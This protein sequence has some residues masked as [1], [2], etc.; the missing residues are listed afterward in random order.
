MSPIDESPMK[1]AGGE[2][3]KHSDA[4]V[5]Q[6]ISRVQCMGA[7]PNSVVKEGSC[8]I[9]FVE[10]T[11]GRFLPTG[12]DQSLPVGGPGCPSACRSVEPNVL[13]IMG[14]SILQVGDTRPVHT[15]RTLC[16][17]M[18]RVGQFCVSETLGKVDLQKWAKCGPLLWA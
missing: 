8:H 9:S 7:R 2:P 14:S 12:S 13:H 6:G 18:G 10:S 11:S 15:G 16:R 4:Q 1:H 17:R 5:R 3:A